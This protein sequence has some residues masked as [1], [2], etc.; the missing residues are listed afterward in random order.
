MH[1]LFQHVKADKY[2]NL[3]APTEYTQ[4]TR[5]LY[6]AIGAAAQDEADTLVIRTH[7]VGFRSYKAGH[8]LDTILWDDVI[9][10][11]PGYDVVLRK[12]LERD[13]IVRQHLSIVAET[14]DEITVHLG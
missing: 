5:F 11:I 10:P 13:P 6:T 7:H 9:E 14:T 8:L 2:W 12:V 1:D 3:F 4:A